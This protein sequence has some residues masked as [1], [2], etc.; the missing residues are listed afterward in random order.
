M[1]CSKTSVICGQRSRRSDS[2]T[3]GVRENDGRAARTLLVRAGSVRPLG[4]S[5]FDQSNV[6]SARTLSRILRCEL[7]AL[8]FA[9]ELEHGAPDRAAVEEVFG[10]A[11]VADEAE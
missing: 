6:A 3:V 7:H 9:Q 1:L 2:E 8:P 11:L 5:V 10:A 4:G